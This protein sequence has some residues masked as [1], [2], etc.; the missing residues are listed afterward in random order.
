[1]NKK[2]RTPLS[3]GVILII[4]LITIV[5]SALLTWLIFQPEAIAVPVYTT[6]EDVF[7]DIDGDGDIDYVESMTV[8]LNSKNLAEGP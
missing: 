2:T 1:M 3:K 6:I 8:I 4:I 5:V 7:M